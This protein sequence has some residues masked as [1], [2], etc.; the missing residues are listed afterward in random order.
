MTTAN[1]E[2]EFTTERYP[3]PDWTALAPLQELTDRGLIEVRTVWCSEKG[4]LPAD[5]HFCGADSN[6]VP[7]TFAVVTTP[8]LAERLRR[9][10]VPV[11]FSLPLRDREPDV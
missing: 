3:E 9:K 4:I 5:G 6:H 7:D 1:E 11:T 10:Q 2:S 8:P